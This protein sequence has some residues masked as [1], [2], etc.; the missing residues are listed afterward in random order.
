MNKIK[1]LKMPLTRLNQGIIFQNRKTGYEQNKIKQ[2]IFDN[3]Q[4]AERE[5]AIKYTGAGSIEFN[6]N[7][8]NN[9]TTKLNI[10][11]ANQI[12]FE[13][14]NIEWWYNINS[15][16]YLNNKTIKFSAICNVLT[17]FLNPNNTWRNR[18]T[19]HR[20]HAQR[21]HL[22]DYTNVNQ[23]WKIGIFATKG[24]GILSH[25]P[26]GIPEFVNESMPIN[27]IKSNNELLC[28]R[29]F[30]SDEGLYAYGIFRNLEKTNDGALK[31]LVQNREIIPLTWKDD[32]TDY[33]GQKD[34][35]IEVSFDFEIYK[36]KDGT[37]KISQDFPSFFEPSTIF[38]IHVSDSLTALPNTWLAWSGPFDFTT[39]ELNATNSTTGVEVVIDNN[40]LVNHMETTLNISKNGGKYILEGTPGSGVN[41]GNFEVKGRIYYQVIKRIGES[42]TEYTQFKNKIFAGGNG[43]QT[44]SVQSVNTIHDILNQTGT[45][46][47]PQASKKLINVIVSPFQVMN[48][49]KWYEN[50]ILS[51][52]KNTKDNYFGNNEKTYWALQETMLSQEIFKE[53]DGHGNNL[54]DIYEIYKNLISSVLRKDGVDFN[55]KGG[56]DP[57]ILHPNL[58]QIIISDFNNQEF[59]IN[60]LEW[61]PT[62]SYSETFHKMKIILKP[63]IT[64]TEIGLLWK[65]NDGRYDNGISNINNYFFSEILSTLGLETTAWSSYLNDNAKQRMMAIKQAQENYK[66]QKEQQAL[67]YKMN[68]INAGIGIMGGGITSVAQSMS[69]PGLAMMNAG[70]TIINGATGLYSAG[71][72]NQQINKKLDLDNKHLLGNYS[73]Q[74]EDLLGKTY[75]QTFKGE[76]IGKLIL[77]TQTGESLGNTGLM[78]IRKYP[79]D[80]T[81]SVAIYE[82]KKYGY[83]NHRTL[84]ITNI[85]DLILRHRFAYI[86]AGGI[87]E[88]LPVQIPQWAK[89]I[90]GQLFI[91]GV[92]LWTPYN[93]VEVV[94]LGD[95]EYNNPE[96]EIAELIDYE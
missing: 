50:F 89:T 6:Y 64:D 2:Y 12:Y 9:A 60:I 45:G 55:K 80:E 34:Y 77:N 27:I 61:L 69:N 26:A 48:Q 19:L 21:Y 79:K 62:A 29:F 94:R 67:T 14:D 68:L 72:Q 24:S 92:E 41:D 70:Q 47:T 58:N 46:Q 16:E 7:I 37:A 63:Y 39:D 11:T 28:D 73:A 96:F 15:W 91:D 30:K 17:T 5:I 33:S 88:A 3:F 8:E 25:T 78:M 1:F 52:P 44:K 57:I 56:W 71:I 40:P 4:I 75:D 36:R 93:N 86:E 18:I 76:G 23:G 81:L 82:T 31:Q 38:K 49:D 59:P 66:F 83:K 20:W 53:Q 32:F 10:F 51:N 65:P 13:K 35:N 85:L 95:Y 54:I 22:L 74:R 90:I 42:P 87:L 43:N 84:K